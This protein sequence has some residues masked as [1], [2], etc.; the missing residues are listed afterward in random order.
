MQERESTR[1]MHDMLVRPQEHRMNCN[2][3][4]ASL[5]FYLAYGKRMASDDGDLKS[6]L[7]ILD[8][9]IADCYP[10]AHLVDT[11]PILDWLPGPLAPWKAAASKKHEEEMSVSG[12]TLS[13]FF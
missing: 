7:K 9:F 12:F 2:R 4:A 5:V 11:F 1:L 8:G 13:Q 6:V 3:F 10:G